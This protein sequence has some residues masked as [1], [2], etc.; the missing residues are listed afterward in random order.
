M[1]VTN[2]KQLAERAQLIR[3]YGWRPRGHSLVRGIGSRLDELQAA[4]LRVKLPH[5]DRDTGRLREIAAI[6]REGLVGTAER[7]ALPAEFPD[8]E[9]V[10]HLYV[11][12]SPNRDKLR[13]RL[14]AKGIGTDVHYPVPTHL[15]PA[16]QGFWNPNPSLPITE[17]LAVEV[18]TLPMFPWLT[19]AELARIIDAVRDSS[20]LSCP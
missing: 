2:D 13:S 12:R 9:H 18:L 10:F 6:Y 19:N 8:R 14:A 7:L 4:I 5:L 20:S 15:Q 11:V 3:E 16:F 17:Q 1:V